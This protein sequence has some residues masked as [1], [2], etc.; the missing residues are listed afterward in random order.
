M[1]I[2]AALEADNPETPALVLRDERP[3]KWEE[4]DAQMAGPEAPDAGPRRGA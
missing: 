1:R 2:D 4:A 3:V